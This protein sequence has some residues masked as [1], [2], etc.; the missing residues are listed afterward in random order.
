MGFTDSDAVALQLFIL[1]S[2]MELL[3][4]LL[5]GIFSFITPAGVVV[6]TAAENAIRSQFTNIEK[7]QVRVDNAP[8]H[9]LLQGK[10]EKIR[11][12][13]RGLQLKQYDFRIDA[14]ELE[15]DEIAFLQR[16]IQQ[17][18][19]KL[20]KPL[21]AGIRL[22]LT[23]TDIN[24][25][26]QSP[27]VL[28]N[29]AKL[30]VNSKDYLSVDDDVV[31]KFANPQFQILD[32]D[33]LFFQIELRSEDSEKS[34]LIKVETGIDIKKGREIKLIETVVTVNE[35]QVASQFV[36]G[37]IKNLNQ[38][39]DLRSWE[40]DG[41]LIRILQLNIRSS[42]LEIAAFVKIQPSSTTFVEKPLSPSASSTKLLTQIK[43]LSANIEGVR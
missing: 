34:L 11:I 30:N 23:Q 41:I 8:T 22:V 27:D 25:L 15:T 5:S 31:Y 3:S 21:Q 1:H 20:Q 33:R 35:E 16:S 40:G 39:L 4:F 6:D 32:G 29:L 10:I 14:L 43:L 36:E 38:R 9:Q 24:K 28:A 26:L 42:N 13:A 12:A 19:P 18:K 2:L 37:I 7:I 17:G